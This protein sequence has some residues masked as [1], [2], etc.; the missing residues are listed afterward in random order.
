M[1]AQRW[2]TTSPK[3]VDFGFGNGSMGLSADMAEEIA[4][5]RARIEERDRVNEILERRPRRMERKLAREL[6]SC[7]VAD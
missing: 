3:D 6:W 5:Q 7:L 4:A 1:E 2:S